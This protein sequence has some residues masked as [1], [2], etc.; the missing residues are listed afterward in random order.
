LS[1]TAN[2]SLIAFALALS[3]VSGYSILSE[4]DKNILKRAKA[5][6][7]IFDVENFSGLG[8]VSSVKF[9]DKQKN[10]LFN[11]RTSDNNNRILI[12]PATVDQSGKPL[13]P[14]K[15]Q[16]LFIEL[17]GDEI[18]TLVE[19][20][21]FVLVDVAFYSYNSNPTNFGPTVRLRAKDYLKYKLSGMV[22]FQINSGETK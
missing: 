17:S 10:I 14:G 6:R 9:L 2:F 5:A 22:K 7:L 1:Y 20:A 21:H 4:D 19:K 12:P 18:I 15:T 11:L 16:N 3:F 13:I 8:F